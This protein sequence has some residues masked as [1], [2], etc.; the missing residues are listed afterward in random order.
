MNETRFA[1]LGLWSLS[2]AYFSMGTASIAVVGLVHAMAASLAVS[3]PAIAGLVTVFALTFA[4]TAPL[5]QVATGRLPRR[6]LL[7]VGLHTMAIGCLATAWAPSYEWI[8][9]ARAP[10]ALGACAVG[11]VASSLGAGLVKPERQGHAL[12]VVFSGMTFATVFGL[13]MATWRPACSAGAGPSRNRRR[14]DLRGDRVH[15]PVAGVRSAP[16]PGRHPGSFLQVFRHGATAWAVAMAGCYM[17]AQFSLYALV[18]PFLQE[19]FGVSTDQLSL[20]FLLAGL[21][22]VIGNLMAGRFGDRLGAAR[23]LAGTVIGLAGAFLLVLVL[24]ARDW[25]GIA[26]FAGWSMIGM[27]FYAPQQTLVGLAPTCATCCWR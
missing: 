6:T 7:L 27:A 8:I 4:V 10:T 23:T 12:A 17:A 24:P 14:P 19:R 9:A 25:V 2:L 5:L 16:G 18:S 21:A 1:T 22:S 11:P 20:A 3:K 13:P 15:D 26:A